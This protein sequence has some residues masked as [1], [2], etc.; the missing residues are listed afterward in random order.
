VRAACRGFYLWCV[1][2][3]RAACRGFYLWCVPLVRAADM[4]FLG[5]LCFCSARPGFSGRRW[6]LGRFC[7]CSARPGFSGRR[8]NLGPPKIR[9]QGFGR[10][11]KLMRQ[12][13][14]ELRTFLAGAVFLPRGRDEVHL[15]YYPPRLTH[16][17]KYCGCGR[18]LVSPWRTLWDRR[19]HNV[20]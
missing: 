4:C 8:W 9:T 6:N 2:L 20:W 3:V 17:T 15:K 16:T 18:G 11:N 13:L 7:F 12:L 10:D 5:R 1:P 19:S 14:Y